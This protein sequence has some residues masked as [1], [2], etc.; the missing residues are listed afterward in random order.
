MERRVLFAIFLCFLVLYLWQT[1]VV[2]P[3]PQP[4]AIVPPVTTGDSQVAGAA[5]VPSTALGNWFAK[6]FGIIFAVAIVFVIGVGIRNCAA[7]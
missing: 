5:G 1:L 6:V 3:V 7:I 2:K 4:E